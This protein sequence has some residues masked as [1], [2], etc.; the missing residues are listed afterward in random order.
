MIPDD[1]WDRV[2]RADQDDTRKALHKALLWALAPS[3]R[4]MR[5]RNL[6]PWKML[7]NKAFPAILT[8]GQRRS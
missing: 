2:G 5:R 7:K 4:P 3:C 8:T 1:L 6:A